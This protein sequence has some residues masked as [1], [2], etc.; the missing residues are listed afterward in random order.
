MNYLRY[1]LCSTLLFIVA[2]CSQYS[3]IQNVKQSYDLPDQWQIQGKL[4]VKTNTDSGSVTIN[5]QQQNNRYGIR[6]NGPLGQGSARITGDPQLIIIEQAGEEAVTS[7]APEQ[8][9]QETLGWF[10]PIN[11]LR[12]WVQG[13]PSSGK[14]INSPVYNEQG[15]LVAFEQADWSISIDRY[16]LV[17][18]WLLPHKVKINKGDVQL[19]LAIRQWQFPQLKSQYSHIP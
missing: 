14:T 13:L 17:D 9:L 18:R 2:A 12:Y 6:V 1:L 10:I 8:L 15:M 19:K 11:D 4:G 16:K 5:W 7:T 3:G